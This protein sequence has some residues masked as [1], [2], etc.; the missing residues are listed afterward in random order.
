MSFEDLQQTE[1]LPT[2]D[3]YMTLTTVPRTSR[4]AMED[5]TPPG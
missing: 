2:A 4:Q 1:I 3:L 5:A